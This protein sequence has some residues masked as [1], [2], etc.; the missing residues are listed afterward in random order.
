MP[1]TYDQLPPFWFQRAWLVGAPFGF[2]MMLGGVYRS[3][4]LVLL[5]VVPQLA[6]MCASVVWS[7]RHKVE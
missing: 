4:T 5:G 2:L 1:P 6:F 3:L 7:R